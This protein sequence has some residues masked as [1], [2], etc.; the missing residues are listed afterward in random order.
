MLHRTNLPAYLYPDD[1]VDRDKEMT[2]KIIKSLGVKV[3]PRDM[4]H[5]D[6]RVQLCSIMTQWLPL[7]EA[8]LCKSSG[9][10]CVCVCVHTH[11]H[12]H[13]CVEE[14]QYMSGMGI[15]RDEYIMIASC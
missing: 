6:S 1:G 5:S 13:V 12:T 10:G 11:T 14:Y 8:V 15:F 4:R 9:C 3:A 7:S 2:E